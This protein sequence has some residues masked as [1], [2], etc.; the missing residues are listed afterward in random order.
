MRQSRSLIPKIPYHTC[1][2]AA[3]VRATHVTGRERARAQVQ[4]SRD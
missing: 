2:R 4:E 3:L 1:A